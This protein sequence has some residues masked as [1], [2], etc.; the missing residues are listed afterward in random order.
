[1]RASPRTRKATYCCRVNRCVLLVLVPLLVACAVGSSPAAPR[2]THPPP[3]APACQIESL[4]DV[5]AGAVDHVAVA[6]TPRT[7]VVAFTTMFAEPDGTYSR[8]GGRTV[9]VD[10]ATRAIHEGATVADGVVVVATARGEDVWLAWFQNGIGTRITR[11]VPTGAGT[12]P[13]TFDLRIVAMLDALALTDDG[14]LWLAFSNAASEEGTPFGSLAR[15]VGAG[16]TR[17]VER[18]GHTLDAPYPGVLPRVGGRVLVARRAFGRLR[19]GEEKERSLRT[20]DATLMFVA[21]TP[22]AT[23]LE[24]CRGGGGAYSCPPCGAPLDLG[25]E[26][27][28]ACEDGTLHA[29]DAYGADRVTE[30]HRRVA[31]SGVIAGKLLL[32][33][34][35]EDF[36]APGTM[37]LALESPPGTTIGTL[38]H[39]HSLAEPVE[40]PIVASA[41]NDALIAWAD[42]DESHAWRVHAVLVRC[43]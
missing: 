27:I 22:L 16:D 6:L 14:A 32:L 18:I 9:I 21:D 36:I 37:Q 4:I 10:R 41:G 29:I 5:P 17:I 7:A 30:L 23:P 42:A 24:T 40:G 39:R 38:R 33:T 28:V 2:P 15:I 1:M 12:P 43:R 25:A 13:D 26:L 3:A 34:G 31:A 8:Q 20:F 19:L 35:G 11:A